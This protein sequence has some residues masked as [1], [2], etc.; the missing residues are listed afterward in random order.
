MPR[1]PVCEKTLKMQIAPLIYADNL[2]IHSH[3]L[4]LLS[5][6]LF[7]VH[8]SLSLSLAIVYSVLAIVLPPD[9]EGWEMDENATLRKTNQIIT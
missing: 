7:F 1:Y 9:P 3:L 5:I 4:K 6:S 8:N 2:N